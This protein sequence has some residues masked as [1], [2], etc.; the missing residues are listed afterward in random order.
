MR[1]WN[2]LETIKI[3][4]RY[5]NPANLCI[6]IKMDTDP[7]DFEVDFEVEIFRVWGWL[8]I[9]DRNTLNY[10]YLSSI[11][12]L[13]T[14]MHPDESAFGRAFACAFVGV[15]NP[16][17]CELFVQCVKELRIGK[18]HDGTIVPADT[19]ERFV[20]ALSKIHISK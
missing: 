16:K 7:V 15:D 3:E 9:L 11:K 1:Y 18:L 6:N 14:L 12:D 10:V 5:Q 8:Q 4:K 13:T 19:F 2:D 20:A 17:R